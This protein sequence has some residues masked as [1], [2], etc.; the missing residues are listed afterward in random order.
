MHLSRI[1]KIP[2]AEYYVNFYQRKD[3]H[4]G[5]LL[6]FCGKSPTFVEKGIYFN[7]DFS[8]LDNFYA[9]AEYAPKEEVKDY[10]INQLKF[11]INSKNLS[12]A[13]SYLELL[14]HDL[15]SLNTY[16]KFFGSYSKACSLADAEPL[17]NKKLF[18]NFFKPDENVDSAKILIDTREKKP[19]SFDKSASMKLDFGDYAV[20]SPHYD[21]TYV[22]RKS[23][24]D[25]KSTM[26]TGYDRFNREMERAMEFD[27]YLFIV[28]ESSIEDIK[29]NNIYGP[30]E[31]NLSF[32]WHNMRLLTHNFPR[33]CQFIF[34]GGREE[35][36]WLI[37]KLLVY[38][39]KLWS[40]D[41]Q[42]FLDNR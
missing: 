2:A 8:C 27:S 19:L 3:K 1:H 10:L 35:S 13:P 31:S 11:R 25:F 30:R 15:P 16:K 20:G 29:H 17:F 9:W 21:Y 22:D 34:S 26:T 23:E 36:E 40:V 14:L 42:Y 39:K 5:E 37:P 38:G 24:T 6:P 12:F 33:K 7:R 28:V 32:I 41:M 18:K 4:T